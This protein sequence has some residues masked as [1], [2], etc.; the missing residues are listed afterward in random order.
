MFALTFLI[1]MVGVVV[2]NEVPLNVTEKDELDVVVVGV[3][4]V[5]VAVVAL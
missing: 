3:N 4:D 2:V 1:V 5:T